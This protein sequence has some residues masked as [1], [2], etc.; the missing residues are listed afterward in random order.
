[1]SGY[2]GSG[3]STLAKEISKNTCAVV[4]DHDVVK[5]AL[6]NSM[7]TYIDPK[8]AGKIS[9]DIDWSLVEFHLSLGHNVI[10][11]SPCLY[12]ELLER[13]TNLSQ[14]YNVKY[15]Y[16]ECF[17]SDNK[18]RDFRL[19][20]RNRMI[21]QVS[22]VPSEVRDIILTIENSKMKRPTETRHLIIDTAQPLTTY[23][24]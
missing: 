5:S 12:T 24:R 10:L 3:K 21:S 16:V 8:V 11:D 23:I 14:K 6:M 7:E 20:T 2:P 15:K 13:G 19:K 17:L 18:E 9:Y 4:V 22:E 1:M